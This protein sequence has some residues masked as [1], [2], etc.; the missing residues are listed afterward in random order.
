MNHRLWSAAPLTLAAI[1]ILV[2]AA[3]GIAAPEKAVAAEPT[4][5]WFG[6][7]TPVTSGGSLHVSGGLKI[8]SALPGQTVSIYKREA[9]ESSETLVAEAPLTC[10]PWGNDF[11]ATIPT[12]TH[13][14]IVTAVWDGNADYLPA[15]YWV[16]A[17]VRAKVG[18]KAAHV[19]AAHTRLVAT[20]TPTQ[21]MDAPAFIAID[22]PI[23]VI[24]RRIDGRWGYFMEAG[25]WSTDGENWC[26]FN[27][28]DVKP[29][30]YVLRARFRGSNYNTAAAS[31][32]VRIIIH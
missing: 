29:G 12:V 27:Y 15:S 26:R 20:V 23:I 30:T 17:R 18:L 14:S 3:L 10:L 2:V 13:T 1:V 31:R 16:C 25:V 22:V 19:S 6:A 28:F 8:T 21:H 24:Q 11:S 4:G 7:Q 5:M 32:A 9:G